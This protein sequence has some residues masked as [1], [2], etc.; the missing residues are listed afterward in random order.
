MRRN[1]QQAISDGSEMR[2]KSVLEE[3]GQ[4]AAWLAAE[5]RRSSLD[6][7]RHASPRD[8]QAGAC[9]QPCRGFRR[10]H[11]LAANR[12]SPPSDG[13]DQPAVT[14]DAALA[15]RFGLKLIPEVDITYSLGGGAISEAYPDSR[16][17]C[18]SAR[19]GLTD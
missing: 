14:R 4:D 17:W 8:R 7:L 5:S 15:E 9:H 18:R 16:K 1:S 12:Q 19:T 13:S 2:I 11:R 6:D 10:V 3:R